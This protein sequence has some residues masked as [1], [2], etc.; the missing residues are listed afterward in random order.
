V[1]APA[2]GARDGMNFVKKEK[3]DVGALV[4]RA[5]KIENRALEYARRCKEFFIISVCMAKYKGMLL[6]LGWLHKQEENE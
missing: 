1:L 3:G 5:L 6:T 4:W 2:A